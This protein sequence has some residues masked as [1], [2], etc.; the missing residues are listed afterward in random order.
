MGTI[1]GSTLA[2]AG[3]STAVAVDGLGEEHDGAAEVKS[4]HKIGDAITDAEDYGT[5]VD[6]LDYSATLDEVWKC[7][8]KQRDGTSAFVDARHIRIHAN[9]EFTCS[10]RRVGCESIG[11]GC[12]ELGARR[13]DLLGRILGPELGV[14]KDHRKRPGVQDGPRRG[15]SSGDGGPQEAVRLSERLGADRRRRRRPVAGAGAALAAEMI[16]TQWTDD[17]QYSFSYRLVDD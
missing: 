4:C 13:G 5:S 12:P 7:A 10:V 15:F 8:V 16:E 11:K 3:C 2:L 1:V 17:P 6:D 14:R 9:S